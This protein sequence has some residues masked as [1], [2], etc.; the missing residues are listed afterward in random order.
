MVDQ[1]KEQGFR[2]I[3]S[4]TKNSAN[5]PKNSDL[6]PE[7]LDPY[8]EII[9]SPRP[10]RKA[11]SS[12]GPQHG[13]TGV[14]A[15]SNGNPPAETGTGITATRQPE[16]T[17][18]LAR[19][20]SSNNADADE[21]SKTQLILTLISH[22]WTANEDHR[23]RA[24]QIND[25]LDDLE[26][27]PVKIVADACVDWRQNNSRRATPADIIK[28]CRELM[29]PAPRKPYVPMWQQEAERKGFWPIPAAETVRG[30]W[31]DIP[32]AYLTEAEKVKLANYDRDRMLQQA[33]SEGGPFPT[34]H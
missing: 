9:G 6:I 2:S 18:S 1:K 10:E 24:A 29:P 20:S 33:M 14:G 7:R 26:P 23:L 11:S 31:R 4:L 32:I 12:T 25:W 21:K 22:Y 17:S 3:G 13:G 30:N 8:S 16:T 34:E 28:I 19:R 27:F 5:S 15:N